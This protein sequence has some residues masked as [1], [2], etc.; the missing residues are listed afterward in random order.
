MNRNE[1]GPLTPKQKELVKRL[2][3]IR[4][5]KTTA[6]EET[7]VDANKK[8]TDDNKRRNAEVQKNRRD[9][10]QKREKENKFARPNEEKRKSFA[11]SRPSTPLKRKK[12]E[13]VA[14]KVRP[15]KKEKTS[16]LIKKLSTGQSLGQAI[17]LSEILDRPV[18]LR[19]K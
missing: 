14:K 1:S 3:Q 18:S 5:S 8:R 13:R 2:E 11:S 15:D 4:R 6:K 16:D 7:L 17:A 12:R 19:R 10:Q 9:S